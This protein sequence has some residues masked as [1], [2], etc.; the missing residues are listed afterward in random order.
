MWD[1]N[2]ILAPI[3]LLCRRAK[4]CRMTERNG[5]GLGRELMMKRAP[6]KEVENDIKT[7]KSQR[8]SIYT[9]VW[10]LIGANVIHS[11]DYISLETWWEKVLWHVLVGWLVWSGILWFIRRKCKINER[12]ILNRSPFSIY[13][14]LLCGAQN[15]TNTESFGIPHV[16]A[17]YVK[18]CVITQFYRHMFSGG[19]E[20]DYTGLPLY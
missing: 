11:V 12:H 4:L 15:H 3:K 18:C 5:G 6:R 9:G 7:I 16:V 14:H 1:R 13:S 20:Y 17:E 8:P 19:Y 10:A 2:N